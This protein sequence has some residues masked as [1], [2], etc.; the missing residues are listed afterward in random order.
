LLDQ[1]KKGGLGVKNLEKMNTSL[2]IKWWWKLESKDGLW[3]KLVRAK[4]LKDRP[5][6]CIEH[7][8]VDSPCW[9]ELLKVKTLYLEDRTMRVGNGKKTSFWD[10]AWCTQI[11]LK[12]MFASLFVI[13][14]QQKVSVQEASL[15]HWNLSYRRWLERTT[16][17]TS[18]LERHSFDPSSW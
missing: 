4:C 9:S 17:P 13:C 12:T 15:N 1:K 5:V 18:E 16:K 11:P 2:L 6:A 8:Q 3:Q 14:E 10:D 7:R